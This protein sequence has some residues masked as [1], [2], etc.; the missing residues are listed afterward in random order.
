MIN[1]CLVLLVL[2]ICL[3]CFSIVSAAVPLQ[4]NYQGR[5]VNNT[6]LANGVVALSLRLYDAETGGN[7]LYED[8]SPVPVV[9]GLYSAFIGGHPVAGDLGLALTNAEVWI[10]AAINGI[11]LSPRERLAS[12]AYAV[13]AGSVTNHA[14]SSDML[15]A[16]AVTTPK[17]QPGAVVNFHLAD[18][19]ISN[20]NLAH[21]VVTS[22]KIGNGEILPQDMNLA[23]FSN[24]FWK[25]DGN[26]GTQPPPFGTDFLGTLD[27]SALELRVH[28]ARV[29]KFAP[30]SISPMV[31]LGY[32]SNRVSSTGG[33]I[34]GGGNDV[35]PQFVGGAY[36]FI[37]GGLGNT[38]SNGLVATVAGGWLNHAGGTYS[39]IG[40]GNRNQALGVNSCVAG[41]E[42]NLAVGNNAFVAGGDQNQALGA[43]SVVAGGHSNIALGSQASIPGGIGN[44]AVGN[45][46]FAAGRG[47]RAT[48]NGTFVWA[49]SQDALYGSSA[50]NQFLVRANR[51]FGLNTTNLAGDAHIVAGQT[52]RTATLVVAPN[53]GPNIVGSQVLLAE[54]REASYGMLLAYDAPNEQFWILEKDW[55]ATNGPRIAVARRSNRVGIGTTNLLGALT[56]EGAI[57]PAA[58][59]QYALGSLGYPWQKVY[60]ASQIHYSSPLGFVNGTR[61]GLTVGTEG[62]LTVQGNIT[63]TGQY[64][65]ASTRTN[66]YNIAYAAF[67]PLDNY[68]N[69]RF[70]GTHFSITGTPKNIRLAAGVNLPDGALV[71]ALSSY[72]RNLSA[73][74]MTCEVGLCCAK[75]GSA[76]TPYIGWLKQVTT[77]SPGDDPEIATDTEMMAPYDEVDNRTTKYWATAEISV[78]VVEG[79]EQEFHG[80]QIEYITDTLRN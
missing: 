53:T 26:A 59:N 12:V 9:D 72:S 36:G 19:A 39:A 46:S 4:I 1:R 22:D 60:L 40:G 34:A 52:N 78:G 79:Q 56:V 42:S 10:E 30:D 38:A 45:F 44:T 66:Y 47:A 18:E 3:I 13:V 23:A 21:G 16:G 54:D 8:E 2:G 24:T 70:Y 71:T 43:N 35:F 61:T 17:I 14:I 37:G 6:N 77:N 57:L 25:V 32:A 27:N 11:D 7:L 48:H 80:I 63:V 55:L 33:A 15:A 64:R 5:L 51:G 69:Y 65:Y 74:A 50:T 75:Y 76:G 67:T 49:D 68:Q 31:A 29:A 58:S 73:Q 41:G 62:S 20:R 28:A